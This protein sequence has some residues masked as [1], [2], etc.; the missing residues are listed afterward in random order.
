MS[1]WLEHNRQHGRVTEA[2]REIEQ[3]VLKYQIGGIRPRARHLVAP[4]G[5]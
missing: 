3:N 4:Q 2:D 5:H 1:S